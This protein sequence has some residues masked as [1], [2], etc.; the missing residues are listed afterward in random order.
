M[1]DSLNYGKWV[2]GQKQETNT[3]GA[4]TPPINGNWLPNP[5]TAM[6]APY[7]TC[8][9]TAKAGVVYGSTTYAANDILFVSDGRKIYDSTGAIMNGDPDTDGGF[10]GVPQSIII[11]EVPA[12]L[13]AS[14]GKTNELFWVFANGI[15]KGILCGLIDMSGN[16]GLGTFTDRS[17]SGLTPTG[18]VL[19]TV[20]GSEEG[21]G[22]RMVGTC[23]RQG[24]SDEVDGICLIYKSQANSG[25]TA[26]ND[27]G[28]MANRINKIAANGFP[29]I[30]HADA[31]PVNST[32]GLTAIAGT[33]SSIHGTVSITP[34]NLDATDAN[35]K[36]HKIAT[37]W[38]NY[39]VPNGTAPQE[40]ATVECLTF[41]EN[42]L[43]ISNPTIQITGQYDSGVQSWPMPPSNP[44]RFYAMGL[45]FSHSSTHDKSY[46]Y[47]PNFDQTVPGATLQL[48]WQEINALN[49]W[50]ITNTG[51]IEILDNAGQK[52]WGGPTSPGRIMA[53]IW[54][55]PH[56]DG[57]L[58]LSTPE[59]VGKWN[60]SMNADA[61]SWSDE[62]PEE[63]GSLSYP[64]NP[65]QHCIIF[66]ANDPVAAPPTQF[67]QGTL[68][69]DTYY[70]YGAP[71]YVYCSTSS[72]SIDINISKCC[73]ATGF[74][75]DNTDTLYRADYGSSSTQIDQITQFS[76][77]NAIGISHDRYRDM[78]YIW[79]RPTASNGISYIKYNTDNNVAYSIQAIVPNAGYAT[80]IAVDNNAWE[81]VKSPSPTN[82]NTEGACKYHQFVA[83]KGTGTNDYSIGVI[84]VNTNTILT[85]VAG[86]DID[87]SS[88]FGGALAGKPPTH[89]TTLKE[90]NALQN[91]FVSYVA[92]GD[93]IA[94]LNGAT[95][96]WTLLSTT[97]SA[98]FTSLFFSACEP[99]HDPILWCSYGAGGA[100]Q[101][102]V[103]N[104]G[105]G[106]VVP[107][108]ASGY[109]T[110]PGGF[111]FPNLVISAAWQN[112]ASYFNHSPLR[113]NSVLQASVWSDYSN[114][115]KHANPIWNQDPDVS[116]HVGCFGCHASIDDYHLYA[117]SC[118]WTEPHD[119]I[120]DCRYCTDTLIEDCRVFLPCC[121]QDSL[122]TT[123]LG[124]MQL[125]GISINNAGSFV[126]GTVYGVAFGANPP[127]CATAITPDAQ[128]WFTANDEIFHITDLIAGTCITPSWV[129]SGA[130]TFN[131]L[132]DIAF[133][134]H[135][136]VLLTQNGFDLDWASVWPGYYSNYVN[137][138]N[139]FAT[140]ECLDTDYSAWNHIV[141]GDNVTGVATFNKYTNDIAT[142]LNLVSTLTNATI[143][144][145]LDLSVDYNSGDYYTLGDSTGGASLNDLMSIDDATANHTLISD[146]ATVCAFAAGQYACGIERV[147]DTGATSLTYV[148]SCKPGVAADVEIFLHTLDDA[149][150]NQLAVV[151]L[152]NPATATN[153]WPFCPTGMAYSDICSKWPNNTDPVVLSSFS[154]CSDCLSNPSTEDCCYKLT[155]C[156]TG[157]VQY[158]T[159]GILDPYVGLVVRLVGDTCWEV[160][161]VPN[162]ISPV[163][164]T[165][166]TTPGPF[167]D[168]PTCLVPPTQCYKLPNC[169]NAADIVYTDDVLTPAITGYYN[170]GMTVQLTGE[171]FC[172]EIIL[173]TCTGTEVA[174]AVQNTL[175]D[176]TSYCHFS[177]QLENCV[178]GQIINVDY[179]TSPTVVAA[180]GGAQAYEITYAGLVPDAVNL[181]WK[182][183]PGCIGPAGT[184][185]GIGVITATHTDCPTCAN[186]GATCV[187]VDHCCGD[188]YV[189]PQIVDVT[190]GI[191]VADIGAVVQ[192]DITV[193]GIIYSGCWEV[194]ANSPV[195]DCTN[196]LPVGD[197]NAINT[198]T[199]GNGNYLDCT[200]CPIDPCPISCVLLEDCSDPSNT[201]TVDGATGTLIGTDVVEIAGYG[202]TCWKVCSSA[203]NPVAGTHWFYGERLGVDFSTGAA[204]S[205]FSGQSQMLNY[206]ST[207]TPATADAWTFRGSAVHSST[208]AAT[209]GGN[210][211]AAGDLMFYTDGHQIYD[212][213]HVRMNLDSGPIHN[214]DANVAA[215]GPDGRTFPA[216]G[217]VIIPVANG[218]NTN[219]VWHQYY[220]IQNS[221]GNGPIKWSIVDMTLNSGKGEVLAASANTT[222]VANACEFMCVNTTT[223][224]GSAAYWHFFYLPIMANSADWANSHIRAIKFDN[225][226]IGASFVSVDMQSNI[227]DLSDTLAQGSGELIVNQTNDII[228]LRANEAAPMGKAYSTW[229]FGLNPATALSSTAQTG[230]MQTNGYNGGANNGTYSWIIGGNYQYQ[231]PNN[232]NDCY[233]AMTAINN[234]RTITFSPDGRIL[235]TTTAT[236]YDPA[237]P[238]EIQLDKS[239]YALF[240]INVKRLA[241]DMFAAS[242]FIPFSGNTNAANFDADLEYAWSS[243]NEIVPGLTFCNQNKTFPDASQGTG[244]YGGFDET[245]CTT[246]VVDLTTGPDGKMWLNLVE[247]ELNVPFQQS[248]GQGQQI[249]NSLLR[250]DDPNNATQIQDGLMGLIP[251]PSFDIGSRRMGE[252]FPVWLNMPC[253]CDPAN[254]VSPVTITT[255][256]NDCT[257]CAIAPPDCYVLTE[258]DCTGGQPTY[259][260]CSVNDPATM[261]ANMITYGKTWSTTCLNNTSPQRWTDIVNA[262]QAL[263][264][265]AAPGVAQ[266]V[267]FTYSFIND[268]AT[269]PIGVPGFGPA[270]AVEQGPGTA[271]TTG[272]SSF[273]G[274]APYNK[275]YQITHAQFKTE[276]QAMFD[277][278]KAMF[279]GMFNTNCGYGANLTVNFTD[280]GYETGYTS[281]DAA[282]GTNTI[283]SANGTSFTDSNGV[284]GIGDFRIG[285][286]DFGVLDP[287]G[288]SGCG[289][290]GGA[291]GILGLCFVGNLNAS[292]PGNVRTS[293]ETGLLL[294]DANEDWRKASDAVIPNSFSLIR[295][296]MHEIMHA[297]GYG[298]DFLTFGGVGPAGDCT[299][300]CNCPCYQ[301]AA[302]CP[303]LNLCETFPSSGVFVPCCPGIQPNGDA[304]MGP[305]S[306]SNHFAT[307]FPTGL[308]GPEGIYD[309]RATC[310]IY[311]NPSANYGCEDGVCLQGSGCVYVTHYSDDPALGAYVGGIIT[312]D[313]GSAA[314]ERCWEVDIEQPCPQGVTLLN[315]VNFT[316]GDPTWDCNDCTIGG[317]DCYTLD[318]C[319]CTSVLGAPQ[320]V[321]TNTDLSMWCNGT[322]GN[323]T[324][325]E[326]DLYP[327]A[328]YEINCTPQPCPVS[329]AVA[330]VV[331]NSYLDCQDCCDDNNQCYELCPC[332][333]QSTTTDTCAAI[334]TLYN[335]TIINFAGDGWALDYISD[336]A[337]THA[338][339][340]ATLASTDVTTVKYLSTDAPS[341]LPCVSV[342]NGS[343]GYWKT[344]QPFFVTFQGSG[345]VPAGFAASYTKWDDFLTDG[346]A[347]G[348]SGMT[349]NTQYFGTSG[350]LN[351]HFGQTVVFG[352]GHID[353]ECTTAQTCTVVTNDLSAELGQV[354]TIGPG[355][356]GGLDNDGVDCYE[357]HLCGNC[358][359]PACTPVGAVVI[360]GTYPNCPACDG[361]TLCDCYRLV[362]CEDANNIINNV[363]QSTDLANAYSLGQIVQI[364]SN[365]AQCW[366]IE[367][368]D[369]LVCDPATCVS[370]TVSNTFYDCQ[371]C[372]GSFCYECA[373]PGSCLC[374]VAAGCGAGTY[375]D[376][377]TMFLNEPGCC[378][379]VLG[380]NCVGPPSGPCSCDPCYTLPCTYTTLTQCQN[381]ASPSCCSVISESYNCLW[382]VS[383]SSYLCVD[384]GDGSGVFPTNA[385]CVTAV[386]NNVQPCYVESWNCVTNSGVSVCIDPGDGSGTYNTLNECGQ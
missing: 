160:E 375:P 44:S 356:P 159:Q 336:Q 85:P 367:C 17:N 38:R 285:F 333:Q 155:N 131:D 354:I 123:A 45:E 241:D 125:P 150:T 302:T 90:V 24:D 174:L 339:T 251:V 199:V 323:G 148:L 369:P 342:V 81:Q 357:V 229:V 61:P 197:V 10:R 132:E 92:F 296:G 182:K 8:T 239:G 221:A 237:T 67:F 295:V 62:F 368:E 272:T 249:T 255:T 23:S 2:T 4:A 283:V 371:D 65:I 1:S 289:N 134:K 187:K 244:W 253:P 22:G 386:N 232:V 210:A 30:T 177:I 143:T 88:I 37:I 220:V 165:L 326:I 121:N 267:N 298:H 161:R 175:P 309:R 291:S 376:C 93:R 9:I 55:D 48:R 381:A 360:T 226:G 382:D 317:N 53:G 3:L 39:I 280:L 303:G 194:S 271:N 203:G 63:W 355:A 234:A 268:G 192:A 140:P 278:I 109:V 33:D 163:T 363:C 314:G 276:M 49:V 129:T 327:G 204:V 99:V 378:P 324:I 171:C 13:Q 245:R 178:T 116:E 307:D 259:N 36:K 170:A 78:L 269:F 168:C 146:L 263:G 122:G 104:Q 258:C 79:S 34:V 211:F 133:D 304:L 176:C 152:I 130:L 106:L 19:G 261:P 312:W 240:A 100:N 58:F 186:Q 352:I 328:C 288:G 138:T 233:D 179:N 83:K 200:Y 351:T 318:L 257:D 193:A 279:E 310:G 50:S 43:T 89:I 252:R 265:T 113:V 124:P 248:V 365:A 172:R 254:V 358:N 264:I 219:G 59:K 12:A 97:H 5:I 345:T 66:N 227:M 284:A 101:A 377:P 47:Y 372:T 238:Y 149:G 51:G 290:T 18:G 31:A 56:K 346:L 242:F 190:T 379:P 189:L 329:G 69:V 173:N 224:I 70:S 218:G 222:L 247:Q 208:G 321:I 72:P 188:T 205:N 136:N 215:L 281:G 319:A 74:M 313:D 256:H 292:V 209:I 80:I 235:W 68:D 225:T 214:G 29:D 316:G 217:A 42:N 320:Q 35:W 75:L 275:T 151:A 114:R 331:V 119:Y 183:L 40:Q 111:T 277:N 343:N 105:S 266:T 128:M 293:P 206:N 167:I 216:Q 223:G 299:T 153:Q 7:S 337:N 142:G 54:R 15:T 207:N 349:T 110:N 362:D 198:S 84:D 350:L 231:N 201:L 340:G 181:C 270:L 286:S 162:C 64:T 344:L 95:A 11:V 16:S 86:Y 166:A 21:M 361:A 28:W 332:D 213:T 311:G 135:G 347:L 169:N 185:Y 212:R 334:P 338:A 32:V 103:V 250:L 156:D 127:V 322:M 374:T 112:G 25:G 71:S 308:L 107:V 108:G 164:V 20:L 246:T 137:V 118:G 228:A 26:W 144:I 330:V 274:C 82:P 76:L 348:I 126:P 145:G 282:M 341:S 305:F 383:T 373:S 6:K 315:P 273:P 306:P 300:L 353:C 154:D 385:A 147:R 195:G 102:G 77:T 325:V 52:I 364:N 191:T 91:E 96:T 46:L 60:L 94:T 202:S 14:I 370:V 287:A 41:D 120:S 73:P 139:V 115:C 117:D 301:S 27:Q 196:A 359:T 335:P 158:S 260:S 180:A 157:A 57:R 98:N 262:V 184:L 236:Y 380:Y 87:I 141:A 243:N 230:W 366:I 294:F 384:P 297:L